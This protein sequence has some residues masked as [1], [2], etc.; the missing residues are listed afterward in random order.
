MPDMTEEQRKELEE[1]LKKMSPEELKEFQKQ[2]CIFCQI[3]SG[4]VP[5]KKVYDDE[6]CTTILDIN[7]ASKGHLLIM[8]KEHYAIMPQ[9]P[10]KEIGHLFLVSKYLSQVMLRVLKVSGTN[11]F[12]ANG[13]IA[14]QR[15][16]HFMLHLIPRKEG[17]K[18]LEVE[19][20]LLPAELRA[21]V[22]DLV[23]KRL[24]TLLGIKKE[25]Q[26]TL[27]QKEPKAEEKPDAKSKSMEEKEESDS[28][29]TDELEDEVGE[30]KEK[31]VEKSPKEKKSSKAKTSQKKESSGKKKGGKEPED[32]V[33]EDQPENAGG[34]ASL[35]D[36]ANL[37]R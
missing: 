19:D 7:P 33:G 28:K 6:K 22:N 36:I 2:Q 17:D 16:Q 23:G 13:A 27:P 9:I 29:E 14:G 30:A 34:A 1:K 4:K 8:P 10:D 12:V 24:N 25:A 5:S 11:V 3:I 18:L 35:D 15:A 37:F 31:P 21:K 26:A 20:K 32:A